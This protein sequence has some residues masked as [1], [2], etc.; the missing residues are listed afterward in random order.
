MTMDMIR[1][2]R[3]D[4]GL[5]CQGEYRQTGFSSVLTYIFIQ[6]EWRVSVDDGFRVFLSRGGDL[7]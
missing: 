1:S 5:G 2:C 6:D 4:G 7:A 3:D